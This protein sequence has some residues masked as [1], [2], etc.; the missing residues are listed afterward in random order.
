MAAVLPSQR[1]PSLAVQPRLSPPLI[2]VLQLF[3]F[4]Q[5]T[6]PSKLI[7][8]RPAQTCCSSEL[9]M[10]KGGGKKGG[11]KSSKGSKTGV[12]HRRSPGA[13]SQRGGSSSASGSR[14]VQ[15]KLFF[16]PVARGGP[17]KDVSADDYLADKMANLTSSPGFEIVDDLAAPS[18]PGF[19]LLDAWPASSMKGEEEADGEQPPAPTAEEQPKTVGTGD[20]E[21]HTEH[22]VRFEHR[23]RPRSSLTRKLPPSSPPSMLD[24]LFGDGEWATSPPSSRLPSPMEVDDTTN[25]DQEVDI[26]LSDKINEVNATQTLT[27]RQPSP[28][29]SVPLRQIGIKVPAVAPEA[30]TLAA[31][32]E[33]EY[34]E[35]SGCWNIDR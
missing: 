1:S 9:K 32:A 8:S 16:G 15:Q 11:K 30:E 4:H 5:H 27:V 24:P 21:M 35:V 33:R 28:D 34:D 26:R 7:R 19:E 23:P 31:R 18:S 20:V 22:H 6:H 17:S 14:L 3:F 2:G 25:A 12:S 10:T 13:D 29:T